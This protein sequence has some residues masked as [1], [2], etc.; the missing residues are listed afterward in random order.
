MDPIESL[1]LFGIKVFCLAGLPRDGIYLPQT[2]IVLLNADLPADARTAA[3]RD[4][5]TQ[6]LDRQSQSLPQR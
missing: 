5:L 6:A 1:K 2:R 4:L 3:A